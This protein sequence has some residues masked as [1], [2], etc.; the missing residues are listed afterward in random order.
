MEQGSGL[1]EVSFQFLLSF[2]TLHCCL[3]GSSSLLFTRTST[4]EDCVSSP[5][6]KKEKKKSCSSVKLTVV[7]SFN[8]HVKQK[9]D[10]YY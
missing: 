5:G 8:M 7:S 6:K 4:A 2:A 1:V 10:K 9:G 3:T